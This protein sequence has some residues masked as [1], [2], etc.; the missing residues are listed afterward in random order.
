MLL[1]TFIRPTEELMLLDRVLA[2]PGGGG[3]AGPSGTQAYFES[4]YPAL[5]SQKLQNQ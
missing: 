2:T 4:K 3:W 1:N 5:K